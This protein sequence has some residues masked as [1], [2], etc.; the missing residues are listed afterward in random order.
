MTEEVE[1]EVRDGQIVISSV[2]RPRAKWEEA[3]REMAR[4][5]HDSPV[6]GELSGQTAWDNE[7]WVR[8]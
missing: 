5:D 7:E 4:L 1:I 6:D 8:Q 3:F 2:G